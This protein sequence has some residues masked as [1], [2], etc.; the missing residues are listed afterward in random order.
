MVGNAAW[1]DTYE[2]LTSIASIDESAEYVLGV[3]GTGFHYSG[4]S[5]WGLCAL[6]SAQTPLK[7]TLK[8]ANDG[9]SFTAQTTIENTTYYLQVPTSN[10][11]S[12]ATSTGTNTDLIIGTTQVSGTNYAVAN[13][14]TTARHLRINGASGLR[15]YAGTTG[16]MAFF[17]KVVPPAYTI[18]AQSSNTNYGTVSL[19]GSVITGS[20]NSGYRY[21]SPA[22]TV[23]PANSATVVQDGNAF[24]V[25]PSANTTVTI[26]FEAIPSHTATFSVN[27]ATTTE[28]F[29]EGAA[30]TFPSDPSNI[31]GKTFVGWVTSTIDA[32]INEA[33]SFVNTNSETMGNSDVTYYAV[34]ATAVVSGDP[35]E[36]KNQTLQYDT[37][38]YTGTTTDKTTYRLFGNDSYIES[39]AFDLSKLSKVIVYGGTF[40]GD[41]Y[42]S[43]TIGDGT[44]IWKS[45]TVSGKSETGT[46]TY[47]EGTALTGTKKLRITATAGNGTS[48]GLRIS[49]VE[50]FTNEPS[51]TYSEYCTTVE[52]TAV[53]TPEISPA[54]GLVASGQEVTIT[55]TTEGASIHYTTD[56]TTPTSS[57]T[58][59]DPSNKPT[60]TANTTIKAIAVKDGLTDS[61]VASAIY[62]IAAPCATPTFSVEEGE[63][64]KGTTVT[65]STTTDDATIYYT[66][67]GS[68]PTT[69]SSAYSSPIAIN[70]NMTIKAIAI[71]DGMA[72]SEMASATYTLINYT[73]LPFN[74]AGGTSSE[75]A[76]LTGVT[77]NGLGSD[78]AA[79]NAPYRVK[80]DGVGDYIQIKTNAQPIKVLIGIKMLG[81]ATTSKIKVQESADGSVF[82]DVEE[83]TISGSQNDVLNL[84]TSNSF[85]TTTR[86]V[87]I[88][89]SVH[90]NGGNIGVG[91]IYI[92]S[93]NEV[94]LTITTAKYA[95]F[96]TDQKVNFAGT[97][98]TAYTAK[99]N[100]NSV[101]LTSI[102]KVP[103]N[104]PVVVY[105]DVAATTT[106]A[107]PVTTA[108]IAAVSENENDLQKSDGT[109]AVGDN[110][111]VL[112]NT[113]GIGFYKWTG[114]SLSA[115]KVYLNVPAMSVST[116]ARDYLTFA[117]EG[118]ATGVAASLMNNDKV[119]SAIFDLQGRRVVNPTKGLYIVNG[120][121]VIVK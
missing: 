99:V 18:T 85:A 114:A 119:N 86:Y 64:E 47:T 102:E 14:G 23:S 20:P 78:Y 56:G 29:F 5:S 55:C 59:Y 106:F 17:Y 12:M 39:A 43:L 94:P 74:W 32:P 49:K 22:Y 2:Q 81:G 30:I 26:N 104:T 4:T 40:G 107:V 69:S 38:T 37:W 35:V 117:F 92:F 91:P 51:I 65:I 3:D 77:T 105:K 72:N 19:S 100:G 28:N 25:T 41:S 116:E 9:N 31:A 57:S 112:G 58:T 96:V 6:P 79:G 76:A 15:S 48:N 70:S 98:I 80:M 103:A 10:T 16:T 13:K 52:V 75:L 53:E 54:S 34:L 1:G 61:E 62:T 111:Y 115:G 46:H 71:K 67:D 101:T 7:Y 82:N 83:L 109:T 90:A 84:K 60:I 44:N 68:T 118:E 120:K 24:T 27:G 113:N 97:G 36:T 95:T 42:N 33:P 66:I 89:K 11:F 8:K 50:I 45:G 121:K 93:E 21:A 88:I 87:K 110:V 108:D 73:T 63:V